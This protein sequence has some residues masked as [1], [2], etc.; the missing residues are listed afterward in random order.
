MEDRISAR[1]YALGYIGGVV[2]LIFNLMMLLN[3]TWFGLE[4][5]GMAAR[6]SFITVGVWWIGFSQITFA[7]LPS[8]LKP[9]KGIIHPFINGYRELQKVFN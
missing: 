3:P 7:Y 2:L 8:R 9:K 5:G 4:P 1:V 6:I